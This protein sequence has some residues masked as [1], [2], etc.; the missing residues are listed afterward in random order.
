MVLF[1][2]AKKE[3]IITQIHQELTQHTDTD[4]QTSQSNVCASADTTTLLT[5]RSAELES[6][7]GLPS[8]QRHQ[9]HL[10]YKL[11]ALKLVEVK[12]DVQHRL[13]CHEVGWLVKKTRRISVLER[14][15]M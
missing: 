11:R 5:F 3:T 1:I 6:P 4:L 10:A 7:G 9:I 13:Q 12:A 2:C 8:D 14:Q 15:I